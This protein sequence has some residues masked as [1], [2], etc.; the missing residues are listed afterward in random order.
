[1]FVNVAEFKH[2]NGRLTDNYVMFMILAQALKYATLINIIFFIMDK[3]VHLD[4]VIKSH[5]ITKEQQLLDKHKDKN[6]EVKEALEDNYKDKIYSP[7]NSG[8]YAKNTAINTRFDFD[9]V[10]PFKRNSFT[11][12]KEM[13]ED[14]YNFLNNKYKD[15]ADVKKQKV[16]IGLNFFA[17]NDGDK[18][19]IDVVPGRELNQDQFKDDE[20]LNL[21]V[22]YKYGNK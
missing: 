15:V 11:T 4:K 22:Y 1:M 13:Y 7:F 10:C 16:S 17:D 2:Y 19:K 8:S 18:V 12:L 14:V 20:N 6:K 5:Q 3:S 9:M 21:S